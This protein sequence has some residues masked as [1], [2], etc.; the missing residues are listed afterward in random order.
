MATVLFVNGVLAPTL[1]GILAD[2]SQRTGGPYRTVTTASGLIFVGI[3]TG[4]FAMAPGVATATIGLAVFLVS[5]SAFQVVVYTLTTI[6]FPNELRASYLTL[7]QGIGYLFAFDVAPLLVSQLS[8]ALGGERMIGTSLAVICA[9]CSLVGAVTF[10]FGR[11]AFREQPA[12]GSG[13]QQLQCCTT[14]SSCE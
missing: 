11:R 5:G 14:P 13:A 2:L 7:I 1:G 9:A 3:P 6:I 8:V 4:L 12:Q 10:W